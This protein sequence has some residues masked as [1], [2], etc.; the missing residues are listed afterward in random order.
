MKKKAEYSYLSS[1]GSVENV[2]EKER[3]LTK[4]M[5]QLEMQV[6]LR[7][8][9]ALEKQAQLQF[10]E[11]KMNKIEQEMKA[12]RH[13]QNQYSLLVKETE[14]LRRKLLQN[15]TLLKQLSGNKNV[16]YIHVTT[17]E[18]ENEEFKASHTEQSEI[19]KMQMS[20]EQIKTDVTLTQM[21]SMHT[22]QKET[23][24]ILKINVPTVNLKQLKK[25]SEQVNTD[26]NLTHKPFMPEKVE[27]MQNKN[28]QRY[29]EGAGFPKI[30]YFSGSEPVQKGETSFDIW[31]YE[32]NCL[33]RDNIYPE[34][35]IKQAIRRSLRGQAQRVS[36]SLGFDATSDDIVS[37]LENTFG[38]VKSGDS[39][40]QEFYNEQQRENET[41]SDWGL[42][43]EEIIRRAIEKGDVNHEAKD[44]MLRNKF[45]KYLRSDRLKQ[46]TQIYYKQDTSF[47]QLKTAIRTEEQELKT[48]DE[49]RK[50]QKAKVQ[51][52]TV[53]STED[54]ET[55]KML[56]NLTSQLSALQNKM[57]ELSKQSFQPRTQ[58]Y[59]PRPYYG[60]RYGKKKQWD[61]KTN[62]GQ[63]TQTQ[64]QINQHNQTEQNTTPKVEDTK[65]TEVNEPLNE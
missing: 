55:A 13:K 26:S 52:H 62:Q 23:S 7:T 24:E 25:D 65:E 44:K 48:S 5:Q 4:E 51:I 59:S 21:P 11:D 10:Q 41:V 39:V 49:I 30:T 16:T 53:N 35:V 36:V 12:E 28:G 2:S 19:P 32:V 45:W 63:N 38:N 43:L 29:N 8:R 27:S 42:R 61:K 46:A 9:K 3:H 56:K 37:K 47:D 50:T 17:D 18:K 60:P 64:G 33:K 54:N 20:P 22:T 57:N 34:H 40:L 31:K 6:Q 15:E 1:N 14:S 58:G